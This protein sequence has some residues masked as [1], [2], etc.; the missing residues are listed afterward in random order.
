MNRNKLL[1]LLI[2][3]FCQSAGYS[4]ITKGNWLYGGNGQI[5]SQRENINAMLVKGFKI[6]LSPNVGYFFMDRFAS[7]AKLSLNYDE[8]NY[9]GVKSKSSS[10][11]IGP[12]IRYYFL[13]VNN[14]INILAET[15]YQYISS[16]NGG[17]S[18]GN[19]IFT[20]SAGPVI[21][22]TPSVG[23]EITGSYEL[24][25]TPSANAKTFFLNI[26]FQIH[27]EKDENR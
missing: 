13:D 12:F 21:Y 6:S 7:G 23:L 10:Y 27:L 1:F 9:S 11:G 22:F 19:N 26:G 8:V 14:R 4:Q 20:L 25:N 18:Y 16:G 5:S 15:S 2:V 3:L 24:L 17:I